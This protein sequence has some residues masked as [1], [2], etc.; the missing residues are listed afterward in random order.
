MLIDTHAHINFNVP[1][2]TLSRVED[3]RFRQQSESG[4]IKIYA[5]I[6]RYA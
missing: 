3:P 2:S 1:T 4:P 6:D 5:R